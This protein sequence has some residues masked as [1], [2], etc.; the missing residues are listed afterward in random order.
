MLKLIKSYIVPNS[1]GVREEYW[2]C[3][4]CDF[5]YYRCDIFD[6]YYDKC[7]ECGDERKNKCQTYK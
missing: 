4:K 5:H 1:G 3:T 2:E 7:P 6:H